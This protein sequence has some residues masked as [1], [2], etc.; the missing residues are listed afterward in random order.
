MIIENVAVLG[1]PAVVIPEFVELLREVHENTLTG[2]WGPALD[3]KEK[4]L[5][6]WAHWMVQ[7]GQS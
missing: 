1:S 3:Q 5:R 7:P 4:L 2:C 6:L